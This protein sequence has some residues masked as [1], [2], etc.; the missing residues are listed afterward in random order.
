MS[1][2]QMTSNP[3]GGCCLPS[4]IAK[5]TKSS[6]EAFFFRYR[7]EQSLFCWDHNSFRNKPN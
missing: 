5:G 6:P 7:A 2:T 3:K 4:S 1:K